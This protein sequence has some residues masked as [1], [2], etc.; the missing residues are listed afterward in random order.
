MLILLI[1]NYQIKLK[2]NI[3]RSLSIISKKNL[4]KKNKNYY[5]I[6]L[7]NKYKYNKYI[8]SH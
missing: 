5:I 3:Q 1:S 2:N 4:D 7:I 6:N 8:H